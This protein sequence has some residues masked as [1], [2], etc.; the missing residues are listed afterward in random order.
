MSDEYRLMTDK[1][2]IKKHARLYLTYI[3]DS[4]LVRAMEEFSNLEGFGEEFIGVLFKKNFDASMPE[5]FVIK[6]NEV[7]VSL[8]EP[9]VKENV[10]GYLA[11]EDFYEV[12][13]EQVDKVAP[14]HP[15]K[16]GSLYTNLCKVKAAFGL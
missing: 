7:F 8:D 15:E 4:N 16:W 2:E 14:K 12:L 10:G 6:D 1:E 3:R 11:F 13:K 5:Y 9:A